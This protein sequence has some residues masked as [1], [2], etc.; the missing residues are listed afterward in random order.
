AL[1]G[2]VRG[3][4]E[5]TAPGR[6]AGGAARAPQPRV[7]ADPD[8]VLR[9]LEHPGSGDRRL[10][11]RLRRRAAEEG[12]LPEVRR[13][14]A[15]G[16]GRLRRDG[17]GR[18]APLRPTR[19]RCDGRRLRS[20]LRGG[21]EPRRHR[22]RQ[23]AALGRARGD[24]GVRPAARRRDRA[25]EADRG[26][27]RPRPAAADPASRARPRPAAPAADPRR[28]AP[29]RRHLSPRAPR[30]GRARVDVRPA[31]GRRPGAAASTATAFRIGRARPRRVG[32][33]ARR[34]AWR[35]GEDGAPYLR[36]A[37]Q[38]WSRVVRAP[39]RL[40][41]GIAARVVLLAA[42]ILCFAPGIVL[43][44]E[45]GLGLPPWDVLH[46]GIARHT[47]LSFGEANLAVSACVVALA[48]RLGAQ[49]GVGTLIVLLT[50]APAVKHLGHDPLALRV[51]MLVGGL[52]LIGAGSGL[53][54]G[55]A[56]G[57]GPRDSLM[58][59]GAARTRFR[60]GLVRATIEL[61]ALLAGLALGGTAG[62]GTVAFVLLIG[63]AV[64]TSFWLL[65]RSPLAL[66]SPA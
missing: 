50:L 35:A 36:A 16:P 39:P 5:A 30:R 2:G 29:L 53:Y 49:I 31:R 13:A 17:G 55:A 37:A 34:R 54:L 21:A 60:I 6:G 51:L 45:S 26:G 27:V 43:L 52:A 65:E 24:A 42:G 9:H 40:R 66:P 38:G 33:G 3:R 58:V 25:R 12:A 11:R 57:A 62:I 15:G 59:V 1:L 46:Q 19:A 28:G 22:R 64:E 41:G 23:G 44:L 10:A 48:W 4:V 8:R 7:A 47:P 61:A 56:L 20:V 63:P 18:L 14:R 32:R